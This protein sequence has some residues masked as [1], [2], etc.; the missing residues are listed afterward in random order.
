LSLQ[1]TRRP[2]VI[3]SD[4]DEEMEEPRF[5]KE[6]REALEASEASYGTQ[7]TSMHVESSKANTPSNS[8]SGASNFLTERAKLER[9]RRE[10]QKRLRPE[11]VVEEIF[12]D[13]EDDEEQPPSKRH[14]VS[15]SHL[16][17]NASAS[18][19]KSSTSTVEQRFWN[20]E[21]RQTATVHADPRKDGLPTFRL[22]E[23]LG[24][25]E[26]PVKARVILC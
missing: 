18:G 10:R 20:G 5:Q 25:V 7:N 8:G 9:E 3:S 2:E 14:Q 11:T 22:T 6:L 12:N 26:L 4:S 24:K 23:I 17:L 19:S 1:D 13:S 15:S 16:R 21:L